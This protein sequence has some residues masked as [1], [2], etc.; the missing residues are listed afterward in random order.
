MAPPDYAQRLAFAAWLLQKADEDSSIIDNLF[1]SDEAHFT[2]SGSVNKQNVHFWA[3]ENPHALLE[4]P[5]YS[6]RVTVW[7]TISSPFFKTRHHGGF[8]G[9]METEANSVIFLLVLLL[10]PYGFDS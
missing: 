8:F 5:L 2:L 6:K 4:T 1:M 7:C 10:Q 3:M 9:S